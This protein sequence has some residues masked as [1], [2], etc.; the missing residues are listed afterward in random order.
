MRHVHELHA[1]GDEMNK[2]KEQV[3]SLGKKVVDLSTSVMEPKIRS[4]KCLVDSRD[5]SRMCLACIPSSA[6]RLLGLR[7]IVSTCESVF[8]LIFFELG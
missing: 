3:T 7:K 6:T 5:S 8:E 4:R 2:L 1:R